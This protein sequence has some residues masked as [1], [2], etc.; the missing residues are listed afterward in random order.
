VASADRRNTWGG[1]KR[2]V[3]MAEMEAWYIEREA[4]WPKARPWPSRTDDEKAA[5]H[6]KDYSGIRFAVRKARGKIAPHWQTTLR[7]TGR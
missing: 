3:P 2:K 4:Q 6:F 5:V 1:N 7:K